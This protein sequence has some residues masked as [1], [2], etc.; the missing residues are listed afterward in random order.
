MIVSSARVQ[1]LAEFSLLEAELVDEAER[2]L[3]KEDVEILLDVLWEEATEE[4]QKAYHGKLDELGEAGEEDYP[5][6]AVRAREWHNPDPTWNDILKAFQFTPPA[7]ALALNRR[8]E[9]EPELAGD[10]LPDPGTEEASGYQKLYDA[11]FTWDANMVLRSVGPVGWVFADDWNEV[12]QAAGEAYDELEGDVAAGAEAVGEAATQVGETISKGAGQAVEAAKEVGKGALE[13]QKKAVEA[14][15]D[16]VKT[17]A[18]Y[19]G[20]GLAGV[21]GLATIGG[22]TY[23]VLSRPKTTVEIAPAAPGGTA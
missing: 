13:L 11:W 9:L 19:V 16:Y 21:V 20:L 4:G 22:V 10:E 5:W 18:K 3:H 15:L 7:M 8:P 23:L 17:V 12:G 2:E 14:Y 6:S 1:L